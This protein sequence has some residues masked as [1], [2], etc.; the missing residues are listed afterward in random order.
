LNISYPGGN[1]REDERLE[2]LTEKIEELFQGPE[3]ENC[4]EED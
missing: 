1:S 4:I 3:K 2:W